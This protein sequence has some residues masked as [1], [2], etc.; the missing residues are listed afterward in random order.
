[1]S[2][3]DAPS[4]SNPRLRD[5]TETN[6]RRTS[7]QHR[8]LYVSHGSAGSS[9]HGFSRNDTAR[10]HPGGPGDRIDKPLRTVAVTHISPTAFGRGGT[11]GGGER[12]PLALAR[13]MSDELPTRLIVFGDRCR[14][15]RHGPLEIVELPIRVNWKGGT[16]NPLSEWLPIFLA[17]TDRVHAHQYHSVVTNVALAVARARR[18]PAFVTDHGGRSYNYAER[19]ELSRMVT[20]LLPVSRFSARTLPELS[21]QTAAPIYGGVDVARFSPGSAPRRRQV[22]YVGRLL[23]HKGVDV[24][25]R[26]VDGNTPLLIV[27]RPY[28]ERYL[29]ELHRLATGKQVRFIHNA[30]DDDIID[31]YRTS[32]VSILPSVY[33]TVDGT[34][35]PWPELLGLTLLE[36]MACGTP[37]IGSRV[38]G[39]PEVLDPD[40]GGFVVSPGD[41]GELADAIR[42]VLDAPDWAQLSRGARIGVTERFTWRQVAGRCLHAYDTA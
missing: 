29:A 27:G 37:V 41:P 26:A 20:A 19:F 42:R 21:R 15:M 16:V 13:A 2:D 11:W 9:V 23:P 17:L 12:Y 30:S 8:T 5:P 32:K 25:I 33:E 28:D 22:A 34:H 3:A 40:H 14:R 38:G 24:L 36:A 39:M 18:I 10:R 1:V 7:G 35:H 31:V 6:P 4:A